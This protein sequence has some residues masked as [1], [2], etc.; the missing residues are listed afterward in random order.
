MKY[1]LALLF[2]FLIFTHHLYSE[3]NPQGDAQ[4]ARSYVNWIQQAMAENRYSDA[5]AAIDRAADFAA[6]SSDISYLVGFLGLR[7]GRG[8]D[9][10]IK[11][12]DDAIDTNRWVEYQAAQAYRLKAEQLIVMRLYSSALALLDSIVEDSDS[13]MLRL[14][15]LR[16]LGLRFH[17]RLLEIMDR[18][19]RDPRP[20]KIFFEYAKTVEMDRGI[21]EADRYMLD[22][23]L[24]RLPFFLEKDTEL[25]WMAAPFVRDTQE[26]RRLVSA[27]REG[28]ITD[29][30]PVDFKP[31]AASLP[32][33]LHLGI[34]DD[35]QA[36]EELF[37]DDGALV[38]EKKILTETA[39]LLRSEEGRILMTK[40]LLSFTG[41]IT[42]DTAFDGYAGIKAYC[43]SGVIREFVFDYNRSGIVDF[44]IYYGTDGVPLLA[45]KLFSPDERALIIWEQ[46]PFVKN[47]ELS[48][49]VYYFP[50]ADFSYS[51]VIYEE[52]CA[53]AGFR[54]LLFPVVQ[55][56]SL[57]KNSLISFCSSIRRASVE[58]R[59]A[60]EE[61]FMEKGIIRKAEETF[62]GKQVSV[63]EF[64][65]GCPVIQYVDMDLDGRMETIRHF[66]KPSGDEIDIFNYKALI[67]S[68]ESDW[69]GD[70]IYKT[71]ELYQ[72]DGST[73]YQW[74][75][76]GKGIMNYYD[77]GTER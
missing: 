19:P 69:N 27:Y 71:G 29:K 63:T 73:V 32:I 8:K 38:I 59:G 11:A 46:F 54:G 40:K 52:L 23:A 68:S 36:L 2:I 37:Y 7:R 49:E 20:L 62:D 15:A 45:E 53:S 67:S 26:A 61:I 75:M 50:P 30:K 21:A 64:E 41:I 24:K 1:C 6:V 13:A 44:R 48:K 72:K 76:D 10:V 12:L 18:Y 33:A 51:P 60:V 35:T 28:A 74:D 43:K 3:D 57:T 70:G 66:R 17:S 77:N 39:D 47:V 16:G 42:D 34:I 14:R 9:E 58:F 56:I 65:K 31:C 22:L 55:N 4:I 25:A 5:F